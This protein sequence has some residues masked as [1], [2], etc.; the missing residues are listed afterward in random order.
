VINWTAIQK[1]LYDWA[2]AELAN[3][4][5]WAQENA[6]PP[7]GPYVTLLL[8]TN[9][10]VGQDAHLPVSPTTGVAIIVGNREVTLE[11]QS[12][13]STALTNVDTLRSSLEK[14]SVQA[15]LWAAGIAIVDTLGMSN[16][17]GLIDGTTTIEKRYA[18]DVLL[19]IGSDVA[20]TVGVIE[21]VE[22]TGTYKDV[23]GAVK[24]VEQ[25]TVES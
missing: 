18:L 11:I 8:S 24:H 21:N 5:I 25:F 16:I 7:D 9:V 23:S 3:P 13:G 4:I 17:S 6:P 22:I 12:F 20:D 19:R 15:A 10:Q 2:N 1:A 14:P